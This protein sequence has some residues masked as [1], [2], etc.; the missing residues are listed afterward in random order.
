[1]PVDGQKRPLCRH[2]ALEIHELS[3]QKLQAIEIDVGKVFHAVQEV[4]RHADTGIFCSE[5]NGEI[6]A[7]D[8]VH[9]FRGLPAGHFLDDEV[10]QKLE[11]RVQVFVC[12]LV[13]VQ[14]FG[15][16]RGRVLIFLFAVG[17]SRDGQGEQQADRQENAEK[18][19]HKHLSFLLLPILSLSF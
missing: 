10:A 17:K 18:F 1:M 3:E 19:L 16:R 9:G 14:Q 5:I 12:E 2:A 6:S 7:A 13:L 11:R 4:E 15:Q 8:L